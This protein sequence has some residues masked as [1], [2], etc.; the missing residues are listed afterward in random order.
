METFS[1]LLWLYFSWSTVCQN[2]LFYNVV[3]FFFINWA[4]FITIMHIYCIFTCHVS[5]PLSLLVAEYKFKKFKF[6]IFLSIAIIL[7]YCDTMKFW[8]HHIPRDKSTMPTEHQMQYTFKTDI[9]LFKCIVC[10]HY[11]KVHRQQTQKCCWV[12]K[13]CLLLFRFNERLS[14][15]ENRDNIESEFCVVFTSWLTFSLES[16]YCWLL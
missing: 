2:N 3:F 10:R 6:H 9:I 16:N 14:E 15:N 5:F 7:H 4:H 8:Y 11:K 13:H 1:W 12:Y